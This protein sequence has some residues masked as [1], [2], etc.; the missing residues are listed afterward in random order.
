MFTVKVLQGMQTDDNFDL[1]WQ[2]VEK[3]RDQLDVDEPKQQKVPKRFEEGSAPAEFAV[4][5]LSLQCP[6]KMNIVGCILRLCDQYSIRNRFDQKGFK[7]YSSVEQLLYKA[8]GGQCFKEELDLVCN[9]FYDDFDKEDLPQPSKTA[10]TTHCQRTT[11]RDCCELKL[12]KSN[13]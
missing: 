5:Q 1:F 11:R 10:K 13:W 9:Y 6:Q 2:K 12:Q 4:L 3:T 7:T 8:Y